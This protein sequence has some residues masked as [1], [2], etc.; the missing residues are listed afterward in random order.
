MTSA[1][2]PQ[3]EARLLETVRGEI[4]AVDPHLPV[5]E[6][7]TLRMHIDSSFELWVVRTGALMF[8]IFGSVAL[9]LAAIGLYGVRAYTVAMRTREIGIRM[10]LGA[11]ASDALRM[12]LREGMA[13][14][15]I[16]AGVGLVLSVAVGKILSN[17]LYH[18]DSF[19]PVVLIAAPALL[20]AVSFVACYIPARRAARLDPMV[21]LRDE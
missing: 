19:D 15:G 4:R 8:V 14:F 5:L 2:N 21:A 7:K 6:L 9:L 16:G 20:A 13:L 12:M 3:A 18:V 17:L 11:R 1:Q 10:A